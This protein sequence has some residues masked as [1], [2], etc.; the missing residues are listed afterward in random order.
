MRFDSRPVRAYLVPHGW[1]RFFRQP[2]RSHMSIEHKSRTGKTYYLHV[3]TTA[4]GKSNHFFS[5][6]PEPPLATS[7]P[8]GYEV[9]EA[10]VCS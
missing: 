5:T 10:G 3:K 6:E 9:Y 8:D 1:A 7:I 4:A 2:M